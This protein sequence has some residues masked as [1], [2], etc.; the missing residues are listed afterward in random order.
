MSLSL[1]CAF[2]C[3][4][5]NYKVTNNYKSLYSNRCMEIMLGINHQGVMLKRRWVSWAM[6]SELVLLQ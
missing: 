3:M 1:I 6:S 2:V 5:G 4:V